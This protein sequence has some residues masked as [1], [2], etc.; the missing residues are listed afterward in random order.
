MLKKYFFYI[1]YVAEILFYSL[2][3]SKLFLEQH[4]L[5][6][7]VD[8]NIQELGFSI[9]T[10][11]INNIFILKDVIQEEEEIPTIFGEIVERYI[12]GIKYINCFKFELLNYRYKREIHCFLLKLIRENP[13]NLS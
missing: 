5:K 10:S 13:L 4:K 12:D 7:A 1:R 9:D 2:P 8:N 11:G 6:D 3:G